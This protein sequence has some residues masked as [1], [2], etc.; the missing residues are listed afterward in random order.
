LASE[1]VTQSSTRRK[2]TAWITR[3]EAGQIAPGL[4]S[5][6]LDY[7]RR[8]APY[9]SRITAPP[10]QILSDGEVV[11]D[12]LAFRR[13]LESTVSSEWMHG[14]FGAYRPHPSEERL[15]AYQDAEL[16]VLRA[17]TYVTEAQVLELI[18]DL[19]LWRIRDLRFRAV[20]PRF[21]KPTPRRV[22]YV[23]EEALDWAAGVSDYSDPMPIVAGYREPPFTPTA[24]H[25]VHDGAPAAGRDQQ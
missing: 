10:V 6:H 1:Y 3:A 25:Y 21:L 12:E 24:R 11:Y 2:N 16:S 17:R 15:Y 18:P 5:R 22:I 23:A 14:H 19:P 9:S 13:W 20:G 8:E 4:T 7:I